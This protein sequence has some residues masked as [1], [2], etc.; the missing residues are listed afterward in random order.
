[1]GQ[2]NEHPFEPF[3]RLESC[4]RMLAAILVSDFFISFFPLIFFIILFHF[5]PS[6][7]SSSCVCYFMCVHSVH[8][9]PCIKY[10]QSIFKMLTKPRSCYFLVEQ[11]WQ[12]WTQ[13]ALRFPGISES[14]HPPLWTPYLWSVHSV[15]YR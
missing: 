5:P 14:R 11:Q 13:D 3:I 4:F 10:F 6:F 12:P 2:K 15:R 8:K 7:S 1:M 9:Q